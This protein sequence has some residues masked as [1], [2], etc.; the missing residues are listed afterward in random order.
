MD[1][2]LMGKT[3]KHPLHYCGTT[4][5]Q[6]DR[7]DLTHSQRRKKHLQK[8]FERKALI[9]KIYDDLMTFHKT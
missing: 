9:Q 4:D 7:L 2:W 1:V 8:R 6:F 5:A 3:W